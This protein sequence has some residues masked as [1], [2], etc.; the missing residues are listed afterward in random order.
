MGWTMWYVMDL[1]ENWE[2]KT[3]ELNVQMIS[4]I[5]HLFLSFPS[6]F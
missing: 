6:L 5:V 4:T 3:N 2:E 1:N